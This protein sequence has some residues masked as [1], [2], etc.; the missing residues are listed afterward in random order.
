MSS[1]EAERNIFAISEEWERERTSI[2][3]FE[4]M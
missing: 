1:E 2:D 4:N 3:R